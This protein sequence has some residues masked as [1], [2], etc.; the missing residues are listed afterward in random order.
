MVLAAVT[1]LIGSI[2]VR[3]ANFMVR[4]HRASLRGDVALPPAP[5]R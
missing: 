2:A 3:S 1:L 4:A 5:T